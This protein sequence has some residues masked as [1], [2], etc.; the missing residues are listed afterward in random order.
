MQSVQMTDRLMFSP[1]VSLSTLL[2]P[3]QWQAEDT[4]FCC[5]NSG[6]LVPM[7][8]VDFISPQRMEEEMSLQTKDKL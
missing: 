3:P 5:V 4:G 2:Q 1:T 6:H 7:D 8:R